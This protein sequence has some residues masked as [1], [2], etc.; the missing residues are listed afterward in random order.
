[1]TSTY[2]Q[3]R[4][5]TGGDAGKVVID[6]RASRYTHKKENGYYIVE[7][8]N[9]EA[10]TKH[11][12]VLYA[13]AANAERI[14]SRLKT[15]VSLYSKT[16]FMDGY[17]YSA[18]SNKPRLSL[19]DMHYD[20]PKDKLIEMKASQLVKA[21]FIRY[22]DDVKKFVN[23]AV[24]V[25]D[26]EAKLKKE[27]ADLKIKMLNTAAIDSV[28][29]NKYAKYMAWDDK[30]EEVWKMLEEHVA[31]Y[32]TR[33]N[34]MYSKELDRVIGYPNDL[35]KE[36]WMSAQIMV[37]PNDKDLLNSYVAN[38]YTDENQEK[39]KNA[40]KALLSVDTS[41]ASYVNYIRHLLQYKPDEARMELDKKQPTAELAELATPITWLYADNNEYQ[42]AYDWSAYS[43][44]ID[45]MSKMSWLINL[46]QK[47]LLEKEYRAYI[48]EHPEDYK[49]KVLMASVYHEMGRFKEAWV[50]ANSLPEGEE[51]EALRKSFN[52]DVVYEDEA[53]QQ[54]LIAN[55]SEL[56]YPEVLKSLIKVNRLKRGSFINLLTS[57]E[58][59]QK[60]TAIQ[61]NELSY[62]F[63][64]KKNRLHSIGA[65]Y[66]QYFKQELLENYA[67]NFDNNLMGLQ[68]KFTTAEREGKPQYW[69]RARIELDKKTKAFYQ[70]GVGLTYSKERNFRS[71][72][73]ELFPVETAPGLNQ[74]IYQVRLNLYQD[75]YLF[76]KINTSISIEGDYYTNGLLSRDT[77][78]NPI[79]LNPQRWARKQ[80]D[81]LDDQS[82]TVTDF[83][84]AYGAFITLRFMLD[85]GKEKK[86]KLIPFIESQYSIGSRDQAAGYPYWM[87]RNR[88][89]EGGGLG[90]K[91]KLTN[92][93]TKLE[94]SY[95]LDD[96]SDNFQRYT[97][98]FSYQLFDYTAL[99]AGVELFSQKKYYSNSVQFGI[100]YNLKQRIRKKK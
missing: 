88:L 16:P 60:N 13:S 8:N 43:K 47:K 94:A 35:V 39:I 38:F 67:D 55:H 22:K 4:F 26:S 58:T 32:P 17:L 62:N 36:K 57:L 66:N 75:F 80:Y 28:T 15:Q 81:K 99:T 92:F 25:D 44:D 51:K 68:Y 20:G 27:I 78:T 11:Y 50:L 76:K 64:D 48:A 95:F 77:I 59:N 79:I 93:E 40:L 30:G 23:G 9:P 70:A 72:G 96:Y 69:S 91:L 100:K 6:W 98:A 89:Y 3:M 90:W 71:A 34:V 1:M 37:T 73:L 52:K 84:N 61:K 42:K 82:Y 2:P 5:M 46:G 85:D 29:W 49:A 74:G 33:N 18:Y 31:K 10:T 7:E 63:Y 56:F 41:Q 83:D 86:S 54:D 87:I 14:E 65:S 19:L 24:W 21:D 53:L 12:G 97:G 45:F